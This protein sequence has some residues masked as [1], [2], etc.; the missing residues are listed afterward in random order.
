MN[1]RE[2]TFA[3]RFLFGVAYSLQVLFDSWSWDT[4]FPS[5]SFFP[6]WSGKVS[7]KDRRGDIDLQFAIS[8]PSF[9]EHKDASYPWRAQTVPYHA[10]YQLP[11]GR[12][13]TSRP[14]A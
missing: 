1:G 4:R 3:T 7:L 9:F 8:N 10:V 14:F 5:S 6:P 13:T 12:E 2:A 11:P